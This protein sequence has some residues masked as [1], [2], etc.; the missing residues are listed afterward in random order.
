MFKQQPMK[1]AAAEALWDGQQAAPFSVFAV[2]DVD[3]GH[4][5]VAIEV[6]GLLSFLADDDFT[7]YVPGINDVN[8]A[9]QAK[10]GA[11]RLPAQH[12]RR[13]LGLPLDDRL[14]HDVH[15][16]RRWSGCG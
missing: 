9:E 12:P 2:G 16:R 14:R 15:R 1:M 6:P 13:L 8:K 10:F 11:R 7:R 4:N 3:K 5:T